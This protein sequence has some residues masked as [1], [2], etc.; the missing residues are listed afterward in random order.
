MI[1]FF[2]VYPFVGAEAIVM[3]LKLVVVFA[4]DTVSE[5]KMLRRMIQF[6]HLI[7]AHIE[8]I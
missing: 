8:R 1:V 3:P 7:N 6:Q 5:L 4:T 2:S